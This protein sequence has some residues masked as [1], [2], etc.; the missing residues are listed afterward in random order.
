LVPPAS[1]AQVPQAK[2]GFEK[3]EKTHNPQIHDLVVKT[4]LNSDFELSVHRPTFIFILNALTFQSA[5]IWR[6]PVRDFSSNMMKRWFWVPKHVKNTKFKNKMFRN[7]V[8][9]MWGWN[10][11]M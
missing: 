1:Q 3:S 9:G 5:S 7:Q 4:C 6:T 11:E 8:F 10:S 2:D